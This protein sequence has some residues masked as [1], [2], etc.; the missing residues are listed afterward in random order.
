MSGDLITGVD[1]TKSQDEADRAARGVVAIAEKARAH[2]ITDDVSRAMAADIRG[3]L[4]KAGKE[5]DAA[6]IALVKP[7]NDHV[8]M[9]NGR[10]K[11][12][13][14][15]LESA[16]R[17]LDGEIARDHREREA[18]AAAE[19]RRIE[20]ERQA[21]FTRQEHERAVR[22]RE[23]M[24]KAAAEAKA[25]GMAPEDQAEVGRLFA[26][27]EIAKP[28]P[29]VLHAAPPPAPAKTTAGVTG[30]TATVRQVWDF[31]V[32]DIAALARWLPQAIEVKRAVVLGHLRGLESSG[33]PADIPGIRAFKKEQV[34]G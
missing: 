22:A 20:A 3:A 32:T 34:A 29:P 31:E 26:A 18:A 16:V 6:R 24:E 5:L 10:F 9:I 7:L 4:K 11:P 12:W 33:L 15:A 17:V 1:F 8:S 14:E 30:A 28:L 21:E 13:P 23:A 19:R 25:A 2:R 27:D